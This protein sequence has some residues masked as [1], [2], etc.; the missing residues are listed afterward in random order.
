[1]PGRVGAGKQSQTSCTRGCQSP[2][3]RESN[4][5]EYLYLEASR[6]APINESR[7]LELDWKG[8]MAL[9]LSERGFQNI[10]QK[11]TL[12]GARSFQRQGLWFYFNDYPNSY[13]FVQCLGIILAAINI[14]N[15]PSTSNGLFT[16]YQ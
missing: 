9:L 15:P 1:M 4:R 10:E 8:A 14:L 2:E 12:A 16:V 7:V 5:E 6:A 11:K 3:Q 13:L